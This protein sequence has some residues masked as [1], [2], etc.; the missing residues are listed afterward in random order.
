MKNSIQ[1]CDDVQVEF[2]CDIL[3]DRIEKAKEELDRMGRPTNVAVFKGF[4]AYQEAVQ[5]DVDYVILATPPCYRPETLEAAVAAKKNVFMEKPAAVDPQG[6]RR[7]IAAGEKA[8]EAGLNVAAGTQRRH[9]PAYNELI[10][11]IQD[12][13]IGD[14]VN[15]QVYWCGGPIGFGDKKEG[16]TDLEWQMRSWYHFGWLSGDHIVEQHVHN[17]DV[18]NWIMGGHPVRAYGSGGCGWQER[19]DIWDHHAIQLDYA[20]GVSLQSMASQHPRATQRVEEHFQGTKGRA[21]ASQGGPWYILDKNGKEIWKYSKPHNNELPYIQEHIDLI[22]CIRG[23]K[24]INEAKNVAQSTMTAIMG[25]M[26]E[27]SGKEY[28]WDEA[29]NSDERYP[30]YYEFK[31]LPDEVIPV[32]GGQPY[33]VNA[34]W[35]PG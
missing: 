12:G 11:K 27:Y 14:V 25:R 23:D 26:A 22:E 34:G 30:I 9:C 28:T 24:Y 19:G 2:L 18:A 31:D 32:P 1:G 21:R 33:D 16:M 35:K 6:I 4:K 10:G 3:P 15:G 29:L 8:K 13:A 17:L 20:N 5:M 7:I